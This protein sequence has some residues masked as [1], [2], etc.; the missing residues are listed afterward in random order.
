MPVTKKIF[1]V[2]GAVTLL[3]SGMSVYA[4]D[5]NVALQIPISGRNSVQVCVGEYCSGIAEYIALIYQWAVGIAAVLAVLAFTYAGIVWLTAGG[6]QGRTTESKKIMGNAII[7]LLL[8]MGSY[9]ILATINPGLVAFNPLKIGQISAIDLEL[10]EVQETVFS[11]GGGLHKVA[12]MTSNLTT[13]DSLLQTTA[14]AQGVDCTLAKA[15]MLQESAGNPNDISSAGAVGLMQ[16]M[17]SEA[18][19]DF[20]DRPSK[21]ALLDTT[22]NLQ[23]GIK[24]LKGNV[25]TACNGHQ[26]GNGCDVTPLGGSIATIDASRIQS[27]QSYHRAL[28]FLFAAYNA[29]PGHNKL[30]VEPSCSGK[31]RWEC[32]ANARLYR[33][34]L[35]YTQ[36]IIENFTELKSK[37][38][39]C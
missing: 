15:I 32:P 27:D 23:W 5:I 29:G 13:W 28:E 3:V 34:T 17:S 24:I 7:G 14:T 2:L 26:S 1:L 12:S 33:E 37:G 38:W 21:S 39:G 8:A 25:A 35:P 10:K 6:D 11:S 18:G 31:M 4:S 36:R 30:S 20:S 16:V 22:T 19:S 9:L